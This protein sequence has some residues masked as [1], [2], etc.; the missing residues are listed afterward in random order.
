MLLIVA[1]DLSPRLGAYGDAAARTPNLD[2]LAAEGVRY[3]RAFSTAGVCAPS[4]AAL[5]MGVHQNRFGAG[6]MRAP[7]G[8]Y[9]VVPPLRVE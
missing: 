1:E 8:G 5:V 4:R 9:T 2:R 7:Q 3:E 6:H